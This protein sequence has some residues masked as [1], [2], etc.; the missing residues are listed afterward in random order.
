MSPLSLMCI[1]L[2]F[3]LTLFYK[4]IFFLCKFRMAVTLDLIL[5]ATSIA[6]SNIAQQ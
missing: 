6:Y 1:C 3:T 2:E 5:K 4:K